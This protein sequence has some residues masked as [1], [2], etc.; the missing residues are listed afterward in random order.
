MN[1]ELQHH[2]ILG[3]KWGIRRY[4]NKDGSLTKE[5][6]ERYSTIGDRIG[7]A[8]RTVDN[9]SI[10]GYLQ[11]TYSG[12][13]KSAKNVAAQ[14]AARA[15]MRQEKGM[16]YK[17]YF[18]E[19]ERSSMDK[20]YDKIAKYSNEMMVAA[21]AE[22]EKM[23]KD[24]K[25]IE[26]VD[27]ELYKEFGSRCDNESLFIKERDN[28][29]FDKMDESMSRNANLLQKM[30]DLQNKMN[31]EY[32][33]LEQIERSIVNRM[34]G[35]IGDK[36]VHIADQTLMYSDIAKSFVDGYIAQPAAYVVKNGAEMAFY[37]SE[38]FMDL[39]YSMKDYNDRHR[40]N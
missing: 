4:Q 29:V 2:G 30:S 5:G 7:L 31:N 39:D 21:D 23:L 22:R 35:D 14:D 38:A 16:T 26:D 6:K 11:R 25:F 27:K 28:I 15:F 33:N 3:M 24:P 9:E 1:D 20:S 32:D 37:D 17:D 19:E 40:N 13:G 10:A 34:L 36:K 8:A 18:S 12:F